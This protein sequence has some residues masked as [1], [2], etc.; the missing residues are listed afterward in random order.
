M[1]CETP[2]GGARIISVSVAIVHQSRQVDLSIHFQY[3]DAIL[4]GQDVR[5]Q[6]WI[7]ITDANT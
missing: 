7:F 3:P 2:V 5:E 4:L 1:A 6:I